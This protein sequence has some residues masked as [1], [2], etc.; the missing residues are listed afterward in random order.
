MKKFLYLFL[1]VDASRLSPEQQQQLMQR[2]IAWTQQLVKSGHFHASERLAPAATTVS[3]KDK[4]ATDGP[5]A[6]AKDVVGGYLIVTAGDLAEAV[7][8]AKGCPIYEHG[9]R[10]EV[11]AVLDAH[12]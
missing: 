9:G 1:G 4:G 5:F 10:V 2:R 12:A 7:E 8:L 11:R 3:G 6:E